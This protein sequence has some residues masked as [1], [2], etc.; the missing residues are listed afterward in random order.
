MALALPFG[1]NDAE[2]EVFG[3]SSGGEGVQSVRVGAGLSAAG[4]LGGL[5]GFNGTPGTVTS[6]VAVDNFSSGIDCSWIGNSLPDNFTVYRVERSV[7]GGGYSFYEDIA[8]TSMTTDTGVSTNNTYT[9]RVR[10]VTAGSR[11]GSAAPSNT[12]NYGT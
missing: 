6:V 3:T 2:L 12:I 5:D 1:V 9:Y 4:A 8:S 11:V 7:N 10:Q